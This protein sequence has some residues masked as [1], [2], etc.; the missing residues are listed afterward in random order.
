M[1][2]NF[3]F[4]ICACFLK[5]LELNKRGIWIFTILKVLAEQLSHRTGVPSVHKTLRLYFL[6]NKITRILK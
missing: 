4:E 6:K 2:D 5:I 1:S 3:Y